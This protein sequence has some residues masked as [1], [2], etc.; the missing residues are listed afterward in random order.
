VNFFY[1]RSGNFLLIAI[2]GEGWE[3]GGTMAE[4]TELGRR[5]AA[6]CAMKEISMTTLADRIGVARNTLSRIVTGE[7]ADPASG[8]MVKIAKEL[9]VSL[10]FLFGLSEDLNA[11]ELEPAAVAVVGA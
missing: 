8:I 6:A 7:T 4:R 9:G 11:S 5:I 3:K 10:D 2:I 1:R